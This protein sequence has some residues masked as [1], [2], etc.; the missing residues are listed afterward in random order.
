MN[1]VVVGIVLIFL[2]IGTVLGWFSR[3]TYS[4]HDDV[5]I[6]KTRLS[7]GRRTRLRSGVWVVVVG[8]VLALA[9]SDLF[10]HH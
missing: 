9:V 5:K 10:S 2:A 6:A 3:K 7:G 8:V 1:P 4:A